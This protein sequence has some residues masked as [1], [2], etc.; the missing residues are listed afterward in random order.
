M[1]KMRFILFLQ[2]ISNRKNDSVGY[3][4]IKC[5]CFVSFKQNALRKIFYVPLSKMGCLLKKSLCTINKMRLE[6]RIYVLL[7][8]KCCALKKNTLRK[9][10]FFYRKR[11]ALRNRMRL[12]KEFMLFQ[13]KRV[14]LRKR[15]YALLYIYEVALG[16]EDFRLK[17]LAVFATFLVLFNCQNC[18][19]AVI[20]CKA[21]YFL[22]I[23]KDKYSC[24]FCRIKF[25]ICT[26]YRIKHFFK[27]IQFF[28]G[29]F[30]F[31]EWIQLDIHFH[32]PLLFHKF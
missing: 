25:L 27:I 29:A 14:A 2:C 31:F 20:H 15:V 28:G 26:F 9:S 3:N 17:L 12:E 7:S 32:E 10:M 21:I 5:F 30:A 24:A 16:I 4:F 1:P 8:E 18:N 19:K 22:Y 23:L 11:V 6:K 13:Q